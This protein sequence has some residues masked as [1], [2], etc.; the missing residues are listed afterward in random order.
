M[1]ELS[2]F[3][4]LFLFVLFLQF[5][6]CFLFLFLFL[7]LD[8]PYDFGFAKQIVFALFV[9]RRLFALVFGRSHYIPDVQRRKKRRRKSKI[10]LRI[11]TCLSRCTKLNQKKC[12]IKFAKK[13]KIFIFFLFI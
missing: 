4:F 7:I 2:F 1:F 5:T 3:L 9:F 8:F 6:F 13:V 10:H 11:M 12:K